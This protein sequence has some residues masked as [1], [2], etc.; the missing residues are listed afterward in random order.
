MEKGGRFLKF[1]VT[2]QTIWKHFPVSELVDFPKTRFH[3]PAR[4]SEVE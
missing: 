2:M 1:L 4:Q 3:K